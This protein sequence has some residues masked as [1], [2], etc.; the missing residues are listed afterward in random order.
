MTDKVSP[1]PCGGQGD[2]KVLSEGAQNKHG[3]VV[4]CETCRVAFTCVMMHPVAGE[5]CPE[6]EPLPMA[7][8]VAKKA[9]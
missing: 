5:I 7:L 2:A 4:G 6:W 1:C 9:I 3:M 8:E